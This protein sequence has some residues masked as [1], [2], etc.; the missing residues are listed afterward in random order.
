MDR[1]E[2]RQRATKTLAIA[3]ENLD[4]YG[5]VAPM[6][7]TFSPDGRQKVTPV[8]DKYLVGGIL[9]KEKP[10]AFI[11]VA[12]AWVKGHT[13]EEQELVRTKGGAEELQRRIKERKVPLPSQD[14]SRQEGILIIG[15]SGAVRVSLTQQ[16]RREKDKVVFDEHAELSDIAVGDSLVDW[17]DVSRSRGSK[18]DD[19]IRKWDMLLNTKT[20]DWSNTISAA[21][22]GGR[23]VKFDQPHIEIWVPE[24]WRMGFERTENPSEK[25]A[26]WYRERGSHGILRV[27]H[28]KHPQSSLS[29][30]GSTPSRAA[31]E[32]VERCRA[33]GAKD[34]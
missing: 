5:N 11:Y 17:E 30:S 19:S 8:P 28:T 25:A 1:E 27:T 6:L 29:E 16:F 31:K 4:Q 2:L 9:N 24:G 13:P 18:P 14:P 20:A 32:F 12:E 23:I 15:G 26:Y 3:K 34:L 7:I 21:P 22:S 10:D 33:A